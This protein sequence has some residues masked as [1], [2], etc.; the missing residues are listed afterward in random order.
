MILE[1][2]FDIFTNI[3]RNI[4]FFLIL[5]KNTPGAAFGGAPGRC[6]TLEMLYF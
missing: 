2:L 4:E 3:F 6:R 5:I 1:I